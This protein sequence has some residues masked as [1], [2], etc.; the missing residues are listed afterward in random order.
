MRN[1]DKDEVESILGQALYDLEQ[2]LATTGISIA[3][4]E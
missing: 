3:S 4:V 2:A 1:K